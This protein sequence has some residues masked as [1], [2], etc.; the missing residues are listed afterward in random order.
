MIWLMISFFSFLASTLQPYL[1]KYQTDQLMVPFLSGDLGA[2]YK[3][4]M[5]LVLKPDVFDNLSG[6]DLLHVNLMDKSMYLK[7]KDIHLGCE[8]CQILQDIIGK[9]ILSVSAAS[10]FRQDCRKIIIDILLKVSEKSPL[11]SPLFRN[12][13]ALDPQSIIS[14]SK[15][16]WKE[17][18]KTLLYHLVSL[19]TMQKIP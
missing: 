2:L 18:M 12:P 5:R 6:N 8:T 17:K 11:A 16:S 14:I 13:T 9:S 19:K 4:L 3:N 10:E 1:T 15:D 7:R